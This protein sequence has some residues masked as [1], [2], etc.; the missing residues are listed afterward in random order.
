MALSGKTRDGKTVIGDLHQAGSLRAMFPRQDGASM[1]SVLINCAGGV[2]GGDRFD[3]SLKAQAGTQMMLTTQAAERIYRAAGPKPG[4]VSTTIE[5]AEAASFH[6]LPQETI[7]FDGCW[8]DRRLTVNLTGDARYL[9]IEPLIF[10]RAAMGEVIGNGTLQDRIDIRRDGVLIHAERTRLSGDINAD[11]AGAA[12]LKGG[13]ATAC[14]FYAGADAEALLPRALEILDG[15]GGASLKSDGLLSIRL[16]AKD[17]MRLRRVAVPLIAALS[18][19]DIPR[20]W[21]L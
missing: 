15:Q 16:I 13:H 12:T 10:G 2:T 3:V 8:L 7:L 14:L 9:M 1:T 17:A 4:R 19:N 11:L 6:W 20:T 18:A 21:M 5:V